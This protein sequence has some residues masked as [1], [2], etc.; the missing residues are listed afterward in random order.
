M[1]P[2]LRYL[3]HGPLSVPEKLEGLLEDIREVVEIQ[4]AHLGENVD[5]G[6]HADGAGGWAG[7]AHRDGDLGT[8]ISINSVKS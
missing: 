1:Q 7:P 8:E 3:E 5:G 2:S 4:P 6:D